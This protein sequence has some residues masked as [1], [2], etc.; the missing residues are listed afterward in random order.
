MF[1]F[2]RYERKRNKKKDTFKKKSMPTNSNFRILGGSLWLPSS[3]IHHTWLF[4]Y[5][6]R[7]KTVTVNLRAVCLSSD[8]ESSSL[9]NQTENFVLKV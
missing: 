9:R 1:I 4:H 8:C 3:D 5:S 6:G 2:K 7:I